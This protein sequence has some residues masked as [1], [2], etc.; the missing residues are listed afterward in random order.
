M[1]L[2][3][4]QHD[5]ATSQECLQH[6]LENNQTTERLMNQ[7]TLLLRKAGVKPLQQCREQAH[8]LAQCC[9]MLALRRMDRYDAA[10]GEPG[11]WLY[12]IAVNVVRDYL[13]KRRRLP[14]Q[15]PVTEQSFEY[16][17]HYQD[18]PFSEIPTREF[19]S[20]I[21]QSFSLADQRLIQLHYLDERSPAEIAELLNIKPGAVRTRLTRLRKNLRSLG[22]RSLQECSS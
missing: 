22:Q 14:I 10:R 12:G 16:L 7:L 13:K 21:R 6:T 15:W 8:D 17:L 9:L 11:G 5:F 19:L 2:S 1:A 4:L 20:M 18:E 3:A